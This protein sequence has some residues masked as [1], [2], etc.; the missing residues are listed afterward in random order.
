[1]TERHQQTVI[2][3]IEAWEIGLLKFLYDKGIITQDE[4]FGIH[5]IAKEQ[6]GLK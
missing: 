3:A 4:Y 1:M 6:Y 2:E 5:K